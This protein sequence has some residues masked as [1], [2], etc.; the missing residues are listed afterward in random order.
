MNLALKKFKD[1]VQSWPQYDYA[2]IVSKV[3]ESTHCKDDGLRPVISKICVEH[4]EDIL[5]FNVRRTD[6]EV[7]FLNPRLLLDRTHVLK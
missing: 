3:L 1:R 4:I 7:S 5:G 6:A 2:G